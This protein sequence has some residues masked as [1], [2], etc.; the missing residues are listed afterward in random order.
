KHPNVELT[1]LCH[2]SVSTHLGEIMLQAGVDKIG[3]STEPSDIKSIYRLIG[4][5]LKEGY[6]N[7]PMQKHLIEY[8][9]T[10]VGLKTTAETA[11]LTLNLPTMDS[12]GYTMIQKPYVTV[13]VKA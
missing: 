10:E 8:F 6:P 3:S 12:L 5:P 4:Y 2:P 9:A 1:Y 11:K 7:V 13:H